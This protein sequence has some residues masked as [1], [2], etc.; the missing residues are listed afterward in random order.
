MEVYPWQAR[1]AKRARRASEKRDRGWTDA[2]D[3]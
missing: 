1:K 3:L 2:I